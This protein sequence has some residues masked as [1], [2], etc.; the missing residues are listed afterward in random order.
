MSQDGRDRLIELLDQHNPDT[1]L[2]VGRAATD[3]LSPWLSKHGKCQCTEHHDITNL[4]LTTPTDAAPVDVAVLIDDI[5]SENWPAISSAIAALRDRLS[6]RLI[7]WQTGNLD[8]TFAR[9]E[10][11]ALGLTRVKGTPR[12]HQFSLDDY[13]KTPDWLNA[14]YWANP[15][16]WNKRRW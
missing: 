3:W 12:L 8:T 16:Q 9:T 2:I 4:P 7:V 15:T 14:R 1:L 5:D 11:L 13:K 6:R 10:L